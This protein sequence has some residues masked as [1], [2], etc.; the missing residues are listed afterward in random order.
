MFHA[1]N[2]SSHNTSSMVYL[3]FKRGLIIF[4]PYDIYYL[5]ILLLS[6][7]YAMQFSSKHI[8]TKMR[9]QR[10]TKRRINQHFKKISII[11]A[12]LDFSLTDQKNRGLLHKCS[13]YKKDTFSIRSFVIQTFVTFLKTHLCFSVSRSTA[14]F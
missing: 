11:H 13:I 9:T 10:I 12:D 1:W 3:H 4:C 8:Q 14:V 6:E 5:T 2:I 7:F